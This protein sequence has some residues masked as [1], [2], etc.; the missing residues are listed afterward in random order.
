MIK[1]GSTGASGA[2]GTGSKRQKGAAA[3]PS[4][5]IPEDI[6]R[7][8]DC[9]RKET[10]SLRASMSSG[11]LDESTVL[12]LLKD[13]REVVDLPSEEV[14]SKIEDLVV[15]I[16]SQILT[17]TTGFELTV[18]TRAVGNQK[19]IEELDRL[20]LGDKVSKRHFL[21]TAHVRKSAIT[22][23][24]VQLVHEVLAKGIHITK[25]DLFYTDVKLFQDQTESDAVL[26]DV[27]CMIGCTRT[28]LHVV[29][30]DKGLVVG[31]IQYREAGD[32]I[33]C[34]RMGVGGKAIPPYIDK[35]TDITSD[36]EFIIL[37]EKEAAYMRL[38]E[39]RF[40][41][42]YPSI[43]ITGKGQPDV[44]T[45]L[46]L[47]KIRDQLKIPVLALVDSDPYGLKILSVYMTGSK[48]MSYDSSHLTTPDIKWLGVRPS[49][50]DRYN[51][52]QQC[53]LPMT[54]ADK[55]MG[56]ELLKE[57]FVQKNKEWVKELELM[58]KTG[59]KAEIQAL[60]SFGFQFITEQ[61]LPRK[62]LEGDWV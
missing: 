43:V 58:L 28:S 60:S 52:P 12:S 49:D 41:N 30:S 45:R 15:D 36:A 19:Y 1:R 16:V 31:R 44:A 34:T 18:P 35:I 40:Y 25:R 37:V 2:A 23:R 29:A 61:F 21:N 26:D 3:F 8:L 11:G 59:E 51:L 32:Y 5:A 9:V 57:P 55:K 48:Q 20:V 13:V 56:Q 53:R 39:D 7:V 4:Y 14:A 38:A 17:G 50:L 33:D 22:T 46:F 10:K 42:K 47:R 62:L 6:G 27:A 24:V 54:E